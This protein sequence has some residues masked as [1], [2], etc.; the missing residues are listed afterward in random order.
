MRKGFTLIELLLY[1]AISSFMLLVI[2][3]FISQILEVR[4]KSQAISEVEQQGAWAVNVISQAI[5]NSVNPIT[6]PTAGNNASSLTIPM[7]DGAK[8]PTVFNLSSGAI[9]I[10]EAG[11]PSTSLTNQNVTVS[12]LVFYNLTRSGT[13]GNIKF[14]F[15]ITY[16]NQSLSRY[17]FNHSKT[18]YGTASVRY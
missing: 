9:T 11:G 6:S 18:F 10:S 1:I 7:T 13:K 12:S 15:V 3:V 4:A 17:E 8:N 2:F 16:N 14:S 5:R